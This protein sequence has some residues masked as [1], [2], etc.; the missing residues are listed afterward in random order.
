MAPSSRTFEVRVRLD[1]TGERGWCEGELQT[2]G[3]PWPGPVF[4]SSAP[5]PEEAFARC[6]DQFTRH[7]R[8]R[9]E[10]GPRGR[11]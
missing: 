10:L 9:D 2:S 6:L 5:S 8:E 11:R 1:A 3:T 7:V 4:R